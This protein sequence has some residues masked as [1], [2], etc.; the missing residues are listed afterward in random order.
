MSR[1]MNYLTKDKGNN[2][3]KLIRTLDEDP[4]PLHSDITPSVLRLNEIGIPAAKAVL[5]LLDASEFL[6][7]KRA[8]RVLEGVVMR[9]HGWVPGQGYPDAQSGQKKTQ[10]LLKANGNY[11]PNSSSS[12]RRKA[13]EKW[14]QWLQM[15]EKDISPGK[16]EK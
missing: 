1:T 11:D 15:Q 4:D 10:D 2:I 6:T 13:I 12:D 3:E 14:R 16:E 5:D 7:R 8:Q 9:I